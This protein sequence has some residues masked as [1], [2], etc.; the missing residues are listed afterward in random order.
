[1]YVGEKVFA[2]DTNEIIVRNSSEL[3]HNDVKYRYVY[4]E[5]VFQFMLI[6]NIFSFKNMK[7]R[8]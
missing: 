3:G 7:I 4:G 1:M 2:F 5:E 6:E 8:E